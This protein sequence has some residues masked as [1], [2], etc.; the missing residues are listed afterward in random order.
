MPIMTEICDIHAS[1]A[2]LDGQ[3]VLILGESGA[4]KSTLL[5]ELMR[6]GF[7][8]IGDDNV[9]IRKDANALWASPNPKADRRFEIRGLG[10]FQAKEETEAPI[11]IVVDLDEAPNARL[12]HKNDFNQFGINISKIS[13]K[14]SNNIANMLYLLFTGK[15]SETHLDG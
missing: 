2:A 6:S 10:I 7:T 13:C 15:I 4:G 11:R 5:L 8:L 14:G 12:P 1:A 9:I 3:A